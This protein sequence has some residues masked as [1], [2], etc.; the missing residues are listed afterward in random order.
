MKTFSEKFYQME[1]WLNDY[2]HIIDN[3]MND[4]IKIN[5]LS[6]QLQMSLSN[7]LRFIQ[8]IS[9]LLFFEVIIHVFYR[10]M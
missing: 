2:S 10:Q 9:H 4:K 3:Y 7:F 5:K 6:E 1:Y 8:K